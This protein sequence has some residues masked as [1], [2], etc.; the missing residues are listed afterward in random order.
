MDT[1]FYLKDDDLESAIRLKFY[2]YLMEQTDL[3]V[4]STDRIR[5]LTRNRQEVL[6]EKKETSAAAWTFLGIEKGIFQ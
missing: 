1:D 5:I 6:F 4:R 2:E 3:K